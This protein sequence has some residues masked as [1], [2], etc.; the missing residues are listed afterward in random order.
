MGEWDMRSAWTT[1]TTVECLNTSAQIYSMRSTLPLN[2]MLEM[3]SSKSTENCR[4]SVSKCLGPLESL[5]KP[6][7]NPPGSGLDLCIFTPVPRLLWDTET[8]DPLSWDAM[9]D[10]QRAP[11][12]IP[13]SSVSEY[14]L[15]MS[16]ALNQLETHWC[17]QITNVELLDYAF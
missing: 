11:P 15:T 5:G 2:I 1:T 8:W 16:T 7:H 9:G 10:H 4:A 17:R 14:F 12:L 3:T 6:A 13:A